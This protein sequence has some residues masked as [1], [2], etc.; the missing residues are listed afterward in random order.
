MFVMADMKKTFEIPAKFN[1]DLKF[2]ELLYN[3]MKTSAQYRLEK[4]QLSRFDTITQLR[5]C[6]SPALSEDRNTKQEKLQE[7]AYEKVKVMDEFLDTYGDKISYDPL[8][9]DYVINKSPTG[10]DYV[11]DK[12]RKSLIS[13]DFQKTRR[14][15]DFILDDWLQELITDMRTLKLLFLQDRTGADAAGG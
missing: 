3:L 14:E 7:K 12:G 4:N 5:V 10:S 9:G 1:F 6:L 15:L 11:D 13:L 8:I 2:Q